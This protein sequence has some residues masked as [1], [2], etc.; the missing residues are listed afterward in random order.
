MNKKMQLKNENKSRNYLLKVF[1]KHKPP[2][3]EP[4]ILAHCPNTPVH[5]PI[6][7][8]ATLLS[9]KYIGNMFKLDC[10]PSL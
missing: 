2:T 1:F 9:I 7:D 5:K 8:D 6:V 4:K 10:S 3:N